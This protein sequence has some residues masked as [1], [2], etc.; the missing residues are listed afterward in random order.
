MRTRTKLPAPNQ[1]LQAEGRPERLDPHS[2]GRWPR[3]RARPRVPDMLVGGTI[4]I[5]V[6]GL[7]GGF[8]FDE[9]V[10]GILSRDWRW[11]VGSA[12][13]G[14]LA[15]TVPPGWV[16][17]LPGGS[18][19]PSDYRV[20]LSCIAV[21]TAEDSTS[22]RVVWAEEGH[23]R[24]QR[25]R[26]SRPILSFTFEVPD[27][28]PES[29]PKSR[30]GHEWEFGVFGTGRG[31]DL[32]AIFP[33]PLVGAGESTRA[34]V[35]TPVAPLNTAAT[36]SAGVRIEREKGQVRID[37]LRGR[38]AGVGAILGAF[39]SMCAATGVFIGHLAF[40][41]LSGGGLG[42][43]FGGVAGSMALVFTTV[44]VLIGLAGLMGLL[45]R[46]TITLASDTIAVERSLQRNRNLIVDQIDRVE[47]TID[48][49]MSGGGSAKLGYRLTAFPTI[50]KPVVFASGLPGSSSVRRVLQEIHDAT[51]L[52]VSVTGTTESE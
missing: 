37:L 39:G 9:A 25:G 31:P 19:E 43:L 46:T 49:Q 45:D 47:A 26:Q 22:R 34:A 42:W 11:L 3:G 44:G 50:G 32:E 20:R 10:A 40:Q 12:F 4:G 33:V 27:T 18:L 16:R 23:P 13:W 5:V 41:A 14:L 7:F 6:V 15:V 24:V 2:D 17:A 28:L 21:D 1:E 52:P 38:M 35:V 36:R 29:R 30:D 51:G 8:L 48:S